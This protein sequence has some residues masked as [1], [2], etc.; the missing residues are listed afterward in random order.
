MHK[1]FFRRNLW[2]IVFVILFSPVFSDEPLNINVFDFATTSAARSA[3]EPSPLSPEVALFEDP[4]GIENN[5]TIFPCVF[6]DTTE[7]CLWDR[8]VSL[9]LSQKY[10]ISF[11][12]YV[13]DPSMI[14]HFTLYFHSPGGWYGA[15]DYRLDK[16]WQTITLPRKEFTS[17]DSPEGWHAI[18][19]I[20]ISPW[21]GENGQTKIILTELKASNPDIGIVQGTKNSDSSYSEYISEYIGSILGKGGINYAMFTDEDAEN[22]ALDYVSLVIFPYNSNMSEQEINA[23]EKHVNDGGKI[24]VFYSLPGNLPDLLG[25]N[26]I[27]WEQ[28][29]MKAVHFRDGIVECVPSTMMQNSWNFMSV[30]CASPGCRVL[31][32][33]E[34]A[35]GN[36]TDYPAVTVG[37]NGAYMS[38]VLLTEDPEAKKRFMLSLTAHFLPSVKQTIIVN[39]TESI[40]AFGPFHNFAEAVTAIREDAQHHPRKTL[41][42]DYLTSATLYHDLAV[43]AREDGQFCPVMDYSEKAS[44]NLYQ[45]FYYSRRSEE[46]EFR[47]VWNHSGEGVWPGDWEKSV[48]NLSE[49]GFNAVFPNMLWGGLARYESDI[50][51]VSPIVD[52]YGDQISQC[53]EA[54]HKHGVEVHV[55]K[56]NWNLSNAPQ[57]FIDDM[58]SQNRTQVDVDGN[59]LDWLC[60]SDPRNRQ[61]ELDTLLEV[62]NKYNVDGIHFDYIRYPHE[63]SCY[64]DDCRT[65]FEEDAGLIVQNWPEDCYSGEHHDAYRDW[66]VKQITS[67]VRVV[68]EEVKK[69]SPEV[70]ISAAVFSSWPACRESIGQDWVDWVN[71]GYLDFLCPMDYTNSASTFR[72]KI[73]DQLSLVEGKVPVYPGVGVGA[74]NSTL[75]PPEV[76]EQLQITR[77]L[78]TGGYILFNYDASMAENLLPSLR[79]G[80]TAPLVNGKF[81][82]LR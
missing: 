64:C 45:S 81:M 51:P 27:T 23:I 29:D 9:D 1:I 15:W 21:R 14:S 47:A 80:F 38:H 72:Y 28:I 6:E 73:N 26:V 66:R 60:P 63:K 77:D 55:W 7:R 74:T 4:E 36:L 44:E 37:E 18:D 8:D 39:A 59:P 41:V 33:W 24:I 54:C 53:V 35:E 68:H 19:R 22:G 57:D 52:E 43:Q 20:R 67:L 61:L 2:L 25:I 40:G 50:L 78:E 11:R 16:G 46:P 32:Y 48:I 5:G 3:W 75:L 70:E 12:I 79:K 76:I 31:G 17:E 82:L 34:D 42:E 65:R 13:E 49:N 30:E 69:V 62:V 71:K 10:L 56:V 58:R